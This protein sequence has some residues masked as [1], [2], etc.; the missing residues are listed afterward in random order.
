MSFKRVVNG[1]SLLDGFE[2]FDPECKTSLER[3]IPT[4]TLADLFGEPR[5]FTLDHEDMIAFD[6]Y[7]RRLELQEIKKGGRL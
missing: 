5:S 4:S 7:L 1:Y 6:S 3:I 2:L